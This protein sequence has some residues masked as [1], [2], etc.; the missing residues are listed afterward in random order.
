[1]NA[2]AGNAGRVIRTDET[3]DRDG[4]KI[5]TEFTHY[6]CDVGVSATLGKQVLYCFG[7]VC[8][9]VRVC[10][11]LCLCLSAQNLENYWS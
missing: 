8:A 4:C 2:P 3:E 6:L 1:M 11:R 5:I 7:S 9:C 10:G